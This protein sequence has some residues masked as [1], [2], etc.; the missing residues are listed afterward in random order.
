M[1]LLIGMADDVEFKKKKLDEL[2]AHCLSPKA[3]AAVGV[4]PDVRALYERLQPVVDP[5]DEDVTDDLEIEE[6]SD[7]T[8]FDDPPGE[9][10]EE[11]TGE[12]TNVEATS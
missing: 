5:D 9:L 3:V 10:E 7:E 8:H 4:P 2:V 12:D 1:L 6:E 11:D